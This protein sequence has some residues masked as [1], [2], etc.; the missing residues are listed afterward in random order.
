M[1][2]QP[3]VDIPF[4]PFAPDSGG[5]PDPQMPAYLVDC[6]GVRST[7][8]GYRGLPAFTNVASATTIGTASSFWLGY[9]A[10]TITSRKFFV[11]NHADAKIYESDDEG[12][13]WADSTPAGT[14]PTFPG[15]FLTFDPDVIYVCQAR[16]P[17]KRQ[18]SSAAGTDFTALGGT[19]PVAN[20]GARV[21]Q[22]VVLGGLST[23]PYAI[24]T[25]AIGDHE[26]WP[27]P[28][29]SDAQ[30]KQ[31]ILESMPQA[32]GIV[33]AV[34]GGE[35]I[36]IVVQ[37]SGLTR[38]TYV[39]GSAVYEL[40][41]FEHEEGYGFQR[42]T[43]FAH[44]G[45]LWYW[46]NDHGFFATD[47]YS[48][49]R[50]DSGKLTEGIFNDLLSHPDSGLSATHVPS[51]YDHHRSIVIFGNHEQSRQLTYN[52]RT[53]EFAF[54]LETECTGPFQGRKINSPFTGATYG[55]TVYN[56]HKT[57][58]TLQRLSNS[59]NAVEIQTGFIEID[60]GYKVQLQAVHILGNGAGAL[61]I[62]YKTADTTS[63]CDLAQTGFTSLT[64]A[65][66]GQKDTA[67]ATAQ[68][69]AFRITGA[70][71]E[72]QLLRGLRV[73]FRRAEPSP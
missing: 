32:L 5:A 10:E 17:I 9:H 30:A 62:A 1:A 61:T 57:N 44:D 39:G 67:R 73:Y 64:A 20:C 13:T 58:R 21:R 60:P 70:I 56:V 71:S 68:Y 47:G 3:F 18:I 35:K 8:N 36:G 22:H 50:L 66:L 40:D 7:P 26:D 15:S 51:A 59:T 45:A 23:D 37:E 14:A 4:G 43:Y 41:T 69:F 65:T 48:V 19:P 27:T 72:S 49:K 42:S 46:Y 55:K 6:V 31:A 38:M 16:A 52:V 2:S 34:L 53:G 29:T 24:R 11:L 25:S 33:R 12:V 54:G 28:G 63:A